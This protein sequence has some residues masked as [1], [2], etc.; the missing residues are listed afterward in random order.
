MTKVREGVPVPEPGAASGQDEGVD[1]FN[2]LLGMVSRALADGR[3]PFT[4]SAYL[5][6]GLHGY[7][8]LRQVI[9]TFP[10]PPEREYVDRM[11]EAHVGADCSAGAGNGDQAGMGFRGVAGTIRFSA[12]RA[13]VS[14][15]CA[16]R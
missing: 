13:P 4:Q 14:G 8:A 12:S 6:A 1:A 3:D 9:P 15:S 11:I 2:D 10:W 7:V 5:W 16:T